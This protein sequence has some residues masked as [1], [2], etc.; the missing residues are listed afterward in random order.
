[1]RAA[2]DAFGRYRLRNSAHP[3]S[4][5]LLEFHWALVPHHA[6]DVQARPPEGC[7]P[8]WKPLGSAFTYRITV[9]ERDRFEICSE[10]GRGLVDY[11]I[12][13]TDRDPVPV[14]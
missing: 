6:T 4:W 2:A 9:A 10:N 3:A 7:G 1:L 12:S 14:G 13:S 5:D 8:L 11:K